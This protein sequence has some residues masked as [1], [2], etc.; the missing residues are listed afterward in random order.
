MC[1]WGEEE[2]VSVQPC[3]MKMLLKLQD[4][5]LIRSV[6]FCDVCVILTVLVSLMIRFTQTESL[7]L[8]LL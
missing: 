4:G 5:K 2:E 6:C 7:I 1:F 8:Q 3:W